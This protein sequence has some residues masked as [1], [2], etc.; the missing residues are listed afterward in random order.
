MTLPASY[1]A[2]RSMRAWEQST[3]GAVDPPRSGTAATL[4]IGEMSVTPSV[5]SVSS[6]A[7]TGKTR[8]S[9]AARSCARDSSGSPPASLLH[10]TNE[11]AEVR[12]TAVAKLPTLA[13]EADSVMGNRHTA[14]SLFESRSELIGASQ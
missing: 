8:R 10:A 1:W 4:S 11:F 2:I 13:H 14:R 7:R 6:A 5:S 12:M 9:S 3:G